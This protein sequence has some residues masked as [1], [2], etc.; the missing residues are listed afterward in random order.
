M[1]LWVNKSTDLRL[2]L[3]DKAFRA[4]NNSRSTKIDAPSAARILVLPEF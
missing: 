1:C 3:H 2:I 4:D